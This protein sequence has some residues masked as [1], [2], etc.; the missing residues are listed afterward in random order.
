VK[1]WG[2][3][4]ASA[5]AVENTMAA[6]RRARADGADGVELDV[7]LSA[8]GAVVVFHDDDLRRLADRPE[9]VDRLTLLELRGVR[10]RGEPIPTLDEVLEELAGLTVNVEIKAGDRLPPRGLVDAVARVIRRHR[11]D[12]VLVSSFNP[13]ALLELRARAP[14]VVIGLLFHRDQA[15]PLREGWSRHLL[16]ARAVHP[17]HVLVDEERVARWHREGRAVNVWTVDDPGE[18][19]RMARAGVDAVIAND[20]G[21]ARAAIAAA[22]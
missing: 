6:F 3:R 12:E 4:G 2:H 5:L 1:I 7:R 22:R 11:A 19:A 13:L 9:R 8:D 17:E 14:S 20:P 18:L 10:A 16:G 21:A 15:R